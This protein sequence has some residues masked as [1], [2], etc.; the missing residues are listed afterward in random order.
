MD[1]ERPCP[2]CG[3]PMSRVGTT[4]VCDSCLTTRDVEAIPARPIELFPQKPLV[5]LSIPE[6]T[7][8]KEKPEVAIGWM[9]SVDFWI[10]KK[11]EA[12]RFTVTV[13][14]ATISALSLIATVKEMTMD[15]PNAWWR[16]RRVW[17]TI[18]GG[19]VAIL[20][21][22]G[23]VSPDWLVTIAPDLIIKAIEGGMAVVAAVL[24][25]WSYLKPKPTTA[26]GST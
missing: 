10:W 26:K 15:D 11:L 17:A 4:F 9:E 14:R 1:L 12:T 19:I 20:Q 22:F 25:I 18:L 21:L 7:I 2:A 13:I 24:A 5:P 8:Y 16:Q 6:I 3:K 23:I